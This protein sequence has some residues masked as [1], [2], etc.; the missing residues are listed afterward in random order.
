MGSHPWAVAALGH[1]TA[2]G[3]SSTL[4]QPRTQ[5]TT[6]WLAVHL[7]LAAFSNAYISPLLV[8]A[9]VAS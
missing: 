3:C 1:P 2:K 4:Q 7:L 6:G 9:L 8:Y 5:F